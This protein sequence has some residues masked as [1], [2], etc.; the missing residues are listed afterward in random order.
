[1]YAVELIFMHEALFCNNRHFSA[2]FQRKLRSY[3]KE[4]YKY[5]KYQKRPCKFHKW[6]FHTKHLEII[7]IRIVEFQ[8]Q[9]ISKSFLS[10]LL[11]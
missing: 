9:L 8:F 7:M 3:S 4:L 1:M 5:T 2:D 11:V 6:Y 10:F